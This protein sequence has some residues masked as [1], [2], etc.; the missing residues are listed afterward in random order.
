MVNY[1]NKFTFQWKRKPTTVRWRGFAAYLKK[2]A[3]IRRNTQ[4]Y[5][6]KD[7]KQ[8]H[9]AKTHPAK[10][11]NAMCIPNL[12]LECIGNSKIYHK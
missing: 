1:G 9:Q 3:E 11:P 7:T 6:S 4:K 8:R 12:V 10:T 5:P 2:S